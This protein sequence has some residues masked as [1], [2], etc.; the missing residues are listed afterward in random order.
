MNYTDIEG[1]GEAC[2][3]ALV[4]RNEHIN[5]VVQAGEG[6]CELD[7]NNELNLNVVSYVLAVVC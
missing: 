5:K 4:A 6:H 1:R 3:D 2:M 7:P